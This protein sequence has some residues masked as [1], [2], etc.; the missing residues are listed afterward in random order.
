MNIAKIKFGVLAVAIVGCAI[1]LVQYVVTFL[2][3]VVSAEVASGAPIHVTIP[4]IFVNSTI[5]SA[6]KSPNG[7]FDPPQNALNISWYKLGSEP[8]EV[9][10]AVLG[11]YVH[12]EK[13]YTAMFSD[14][15][16]LVP[17]DVVQVKNDRGIEISFIVRESKTYDLNSD[18][19]MVF[20]SSDDVAHLNLITFDGVWSTTTKDYSKRLVVFTDKVIATTTP[21]ACFTNG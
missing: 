2:P 1:L 8:G 21:F 14:L 6:T 15:H 13:G 17:G 9:G 19:S 18:I 20:N 11:G 5:E 7:L 16:L 10:S 4:K 12:W 3:L